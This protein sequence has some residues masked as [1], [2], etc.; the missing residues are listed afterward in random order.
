MICKVF[1]KNIKLL[2]YFVFIMVEKFV[3]DFFSFNEM[4]YIIFLDQ[5]F[6]VKL[7]NWI[8]VLWVDGVVLEKVQEDEF[9]Y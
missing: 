9:C 4:K 7:E 8:D 1:F 3:G 2:C 5:D 6:V